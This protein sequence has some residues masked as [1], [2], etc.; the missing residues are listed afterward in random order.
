[1][2]FLFAGLLIVWVFVLAALGLTDLVL[3]LVRQPTI[4]DHVWDHPWLG[5]PIV[6]WAAIG[7][8]ILAGHFWLG[9]FRE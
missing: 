5:I 4:S 3:I 2:A 7:P 6:A 1:M 8:V 9:W